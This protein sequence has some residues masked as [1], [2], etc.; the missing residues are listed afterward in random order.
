MVSVEGEL[1]SVQADVDEALF[2]VGTMQTELDFILTET[3]R[4]S[5]QVVRFDNFLVGLE[6]LMRAISDTELVE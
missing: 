6:E 3:T 2:T 4:L 5:E 1:G